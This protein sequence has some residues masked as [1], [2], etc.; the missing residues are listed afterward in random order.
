MPVALHGE[1]NPRIPLR[2]VYKQYFHIGF[3]ADTP[4]G[5]MVP[6]LKDADKKASSKSAP[7]WANSPKKHA[8]ANSA[9]QK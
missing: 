8:M 7:K 2:M 5:L 1:F 9:P 3:A 6:V 4:N